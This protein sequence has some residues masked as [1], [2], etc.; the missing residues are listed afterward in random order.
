MGNKIKITQ[1][2]IGMYP[3]DWA[4]A[5]M[6]AKAYFI[7]TSAAM[8][9]IVDHWRQTRDSAQATRLRKLAESYLRE[10]ITADEFSTEAGILILVGGH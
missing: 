6:L 9:I 5:E 2:N 10:K 3:D 8:R 4:E 7:S 1:R